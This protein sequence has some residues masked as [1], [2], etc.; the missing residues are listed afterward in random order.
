LKNTSFTSDH[1]ILCRKFRL[2]LRTGSNATNG[3][4][5][6]IF[7]EPGNFRKDIFWL[8]YNIK[9]YIIQS[10]TNLYFIKLYIYIYIYICR[11]QWPYGLRRRSAAARLLRSWVRILLVASVVSVVYC[12]VEVSATS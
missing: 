4:F 11:S 2:T 10:G 12:Q 1:V 8:K 5:L 3:V 6:T 9:I 7:T